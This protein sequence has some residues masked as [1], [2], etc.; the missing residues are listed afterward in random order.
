MVKIDF[1]KELKH[2]YS[3]SAKEVV[4]VD[5]PAMNFL[6]VDGAGDPNTA[7]QYREAVEA[8]FS[9]SYTIKFM[10][11]KDNG[12]DYGVMPLERLWWVDDM[13]KFSTEHKDEWKWTSMI[14]QPKYVT[15]KHV[16]AAIETVR[17]KKTLPALSKLR[18]ESFHEVAAA[19]IMHIGPYSAEG[20]NIAKIHSFIRNSGHVL[21]GKHHE[22]YL[23]DLRRTAPEKLKSILRQPMT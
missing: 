22:I 1:K 3:S 6:M 12:V 23:N 21:S 2:L 14:M 16:N 20:P 15:A 5:V 11:K 17:K 9:V 19:Q 10:I 13:T 4:A 8:L 18:F 7:Q